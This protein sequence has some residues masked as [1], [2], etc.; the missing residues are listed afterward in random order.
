[1][2]GRLVELLA[3]LEAEDVDFILVGGMA[4]VLHGA[5]I[6]TQDLD[7]VP[8][9]EAG[10]ISRLQRVLA[11]LNARYRGQPSGRII[12]PTDEALAGA[13]HN[14]LMTDLGPIDVLGELAPGQGYDQILPHTTR[15]TDGSVCL[16]VISLEKLIEVKTEAGR[17]KDRLVLPILMKLLKGE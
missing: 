5:P 8:L 3:R 17:A 9:R 12:R 16:N 4:A 13:G 14:N 1:M 15:M 7:I 11:D 2:T 6:T 10:N